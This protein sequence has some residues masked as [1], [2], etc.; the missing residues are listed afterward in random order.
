MALVDSESAFRKR[1]DQLQA[2]LA[3]KTEAQSLTTFQRLRF[4][5]G[6]HRTKFQMRRS[7]SLLNQFMVHQV[8]VMWQLLEDCTLSHAR[9]FS[10]T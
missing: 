3:D 10:M 9:I 6:L 2:G 8:W 1:C 5:S 4:Q 7:Q